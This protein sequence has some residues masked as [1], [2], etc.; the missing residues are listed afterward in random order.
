[1]T[2]HEKLMRAKRHVEAVTGFYIHL[3]IFTLVIAS[4][5][6]VDVTTGPEWWVQWPFLGWGIGILAHASAVFGRVP[7]LI[8]TWQLRKIRD[9]KSKM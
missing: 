3:L 1:M 2:E 8:T 6:V 4:L 5:F 9:V 7:N